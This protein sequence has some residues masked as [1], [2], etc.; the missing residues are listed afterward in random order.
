MPKGNRAGGG[1]R[2]GDGK[3]SVSAA[4]PHR[5]PPNCH[6]SL[7]VNRVLYKI[8]GLDAVFSEIDPVFALC[9]DRSFNS[10]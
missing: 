4:P 7:E 8:H 10:C 9:F 2:W 1:G 5:P 6:N 3:H